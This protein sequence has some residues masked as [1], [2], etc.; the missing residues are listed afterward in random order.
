MLVHGVQPQDESGVTHAPKVRP[1]TT[2]I[3]WSTRSMREIDCMYRA[4]AH[5]VCTHAIVLV[6]R[7]AK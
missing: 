3:D 5:Q 1:A 2:L 4:F 6:Q 7:F